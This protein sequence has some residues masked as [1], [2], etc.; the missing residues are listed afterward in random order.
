MVA[1]T[2]GKAQTAIL[3]YT[4]GPAEWLTL[5]PDTG[6]PPHLPLGNSG[7]R[8][9][10]T[11]SAQGIDVSTNSRLVRRPWVGQH[12]LWAPHLYDWLKRATDIPSHQVH[13]TSIPAHQPTCK[14]WALSWWVD[15][16]C[17]I[18]RPQYPRYPADVFD[19][20][21]FLFTPTSPS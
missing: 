6:M 7:T 10:K 19:L 16:N 21:S 1:S 8:R 15:H 5:K 13:I 9:P 14:N 3:Q 11:L 4:W 20:W 17:G 12:L 2:C 18:L